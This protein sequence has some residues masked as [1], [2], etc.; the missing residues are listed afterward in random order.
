MNKQYVFTDAEYCAIRAN[1]LNTYNS[2]AKRVDEDYENY[3]VGDMMAYHD[4]KY[5]LDILDG[6][7]ELKDYM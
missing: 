3:N 1:V 7:I 2:I 5:V 6:D 4:L